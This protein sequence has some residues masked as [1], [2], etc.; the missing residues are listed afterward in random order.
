MKNS[1]KSHLLVGIQL[2]FFLGI[3]YSVNAQTVKWISTTAQAKWVEQTPIKL[4]NKNSDKQDSVLIID[5]KATAQ[6]ITGWGG[7]FNEL[8]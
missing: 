3:F 5:T 7:C 8:G 1:T 6:Q 2:V 4:Q